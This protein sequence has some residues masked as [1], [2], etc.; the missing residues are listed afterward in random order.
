MRKVATIFVL[1]VFGPSLVLAWLAV[2]SL[3]DQQ[4]L[5]ERQQVL[6]CQSE[7]LAIA[8]GI[9]GRLAEHQREFGLQVEAM[10]AG[11]PASAVAAVFDQHLPDIWPWAEVGFV[12]SLDGAILS[13]APPAGAHSRQFLSENDLFFSNRGTLEVYNNPKSVNYSQLA[14]AQQ[15]MRQI[16][17]PGPQAILPVEPAAVQARPPPPTRNVAV[18][19]QVVPLN[20]PQAADNYFSRLAASEAHFRDLIGDAAEGSLARFVGSQLRLWIWRRSPQDPQLVFGAQLDLSRLRQDLQERFLVLPGARPSAATARDS[21][22]RADLRGRVCLALIDEAGRPLARSHPNFQADWR[23]PFV[24]TEIGEILPRWEVCAYLLDPAQLARMAASIRLTLGFLV[25]VLLSAIAAGGWLVVR[26]L[27]RELTLARQKTDFVSNVSHELKT[28]LTSIRMFAELLADGRVT[29]A[30]KQ[31]DYL[32]IITVEAGRLARLIN[33]VLDFS[34]LERGEKKFQFLAC[35]LVEIVRETAESFRPH[36]QSNGFALEC[37]LPP[38]P[39][40]VRGDRDGLAQILV[41]LLSNAEKYSGDGRE[42]EVRV[43][44]GSD[45]AVVEIEV[46]DRGMGV[47]RGCEEKIFEKFFRAHDTLASGIQGSGLG[48][49]LARQV[50]R[51]HGG[52]L[53]Y[54]P[55]AGGG[56][57]FLLR[58]PR[59]GPAA[60]GPAPILENLD[61]C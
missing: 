41:N 16:G 15:A 52:D 21:Q 19:R 28:P 55:R 56:S 32:R 27:R 4:F 43:A 12:A 49:T 13:P 6:L 44:D 59:A 9:N 31:R 22:P 23:H 45:P 54:R 17:G 38:E 18:P 48:L 50:A 61:A 33:N 57:C 29:Q 47:P 58:L 24:A 14:E 25:A 35:D 30:E 2:R 8:G 5:L 10:L 37:R 7:V 36:L 1:S 11:Q 42:I 51:A 53:D 46:L 3:R 20:D 39:R 26:D 40:M 60:P 34:R